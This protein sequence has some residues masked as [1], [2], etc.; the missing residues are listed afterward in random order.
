MK[1]AVFIDKDGTLINDV[2][3]NADPAKITLAPGA[4]ESLRRLRQAG[5][6]LI[7]VTNQSGVAH[8]YFREIMLVGVF[9]YINSLLRD[10]GAYLDGFYYCPHHP[11]ASLQRYRMNCICRKPHNGM[12]LQAAKEH[13]IDLSSSWMIGDILDDMEAGNQAGCKTILIDQGHETMW[14]LNRSRT[15]SFQVNAWPEATDIIIE[16]SKNP[17]YGLTY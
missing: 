13:H 17:V 5:H 8:G 10:E 6:T 3:Y 2:P 16:H 4:G 14:Q 11:Q 15:P 12:L 9:N 1:K 7:L